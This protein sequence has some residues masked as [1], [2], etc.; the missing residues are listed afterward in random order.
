MEV[1]AF[2]VLYREVSIVR[3][4]EKEKAY[5]FRSPEGEINKPQGIAKD[6][7]F[8]VTSLFRDTIHFTQ[9]IWMVEIFEVLG[10]LNVRLERFNDI[11]MVQ[12]DPC[13]MVSMNL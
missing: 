2:D 11:G 6:V 13:S 7:T 1:E 3:K 10:T 9:D 4:R 5:V 8:A 12:Q